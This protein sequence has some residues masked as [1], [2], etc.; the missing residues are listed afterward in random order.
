MKENLEYKLGIEINKG[1]TAIPPGVE[2]GS[3]KAIVNVIE[4][5]DIDVIKVVDEPSAAAKVLK[6]KMEQL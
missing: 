4:S 3:V 6:I 2:S 1:F 5:A